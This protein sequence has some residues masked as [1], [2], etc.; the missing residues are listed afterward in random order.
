[1]LVRTISL[2][3]FMS[4]IYVMRLYLP[5]LHVLNGHNSFIAPP[6]DAYLDGAC[7]T[8]SL[9]VPNFLSLYTLFRFVRQ[10]EL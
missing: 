8:D 6:N 9:T 5:A 1:M 2:V 10:T 4:L 3:P 7:Y